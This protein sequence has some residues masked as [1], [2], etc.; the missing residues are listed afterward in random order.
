[1]YV[2]IPALI[3]PKDFKGLY[4]MNA[5]KWFYCRTYPYK[6]KGAYIG[7]LPVDVL[8]CYHQYLLSQMYPTYFVLVTRIKSD[9]RRKNYV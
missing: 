2:S 5:K 9:T 7:R 4:E 6:H 8:T 1:M 3:T